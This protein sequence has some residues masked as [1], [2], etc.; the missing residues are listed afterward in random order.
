MSR[1]QGLLTSFGFA[2]L[3]LALGSPP[4][5][6]AAD[7]DADEDGGKVA[8]IMFD[9]KPGEWITVRADGADE[10]VKYVIGSDTKVVAAMKNIFPASRVQLTWKK[11]GD[12]RVLV[13][14]SKQFRAN[15]VPRTVTGTVVKVH[16]D[17]WVEVK[18]PKG[19][20]DAYAPGAN[21][22]D[23]EFMSRL[24]ALQPGDSVTITFTTDEERH[25][26]VS[27]KKN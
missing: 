14:I 18:P 2:L 23:K 8:G 25:R 21:Y 9:F 17:F 13:A 4:A 19:P 3:C 20:P 12:A 22:N 15:P 16:N 10:P 26:I 7:D 1:S 24:K 5:A 11:D 6:S 27:L